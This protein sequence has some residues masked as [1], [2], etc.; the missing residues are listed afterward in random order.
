MKLDSSEARLLK[1]VLHR[2]GLTRHDLAAAMQ[3]SVPT[4]ASLVR[5]LSTSGAVVQS[6][7]A[8]STGGRPASRISISP[9]FGHCY[10]HQIL[11]GRLAS[12]A[13]DAQGKVLAQVDRPVKD[14]PTTFRAVDAAEMELSVKVPDRPALASTL[15]VPG[16]VDRTSN[17]GIAPWVYGLQHFEPA[18]AGCASRLV[19]SAG[20]LYAM[21]VFGQGVP[22]TGRWVAID[23]A[24]GLS[25]VFVSDK[26]EV[27]PLELTALDPTRSIV[28]KEEVEAAI[29]EAAKSPGSAIEK[30]LAQL[31]PIEA[32]C[33]AERAGDE[34][35]C[36]L[37]DST[38]S[39]TAEFVRSACR[40]MRPRRILLC[41]WLLDG[42]RCHESVRAA[43]SRKAG[44][45]AG[46]LVL[47]SPKDAV[48][49]RWI[50]AGLAGLDMRLAEMESGCKQV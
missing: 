23:M 3:T 27:V 39:R 29:L 50:G 7:A 20:A 49:Q 31:S 9:G 41:F 18:G 4:I 11:E 22:F 42:M 19:S 10:A 37:F 13:I 28:C 16:I 46:S 38:V 26:Q 21:Q 34:K 15:V 44:V 35:A 36:E 48:E 12:C 2:P 45:P 8:T 43:I 1:L 32:L 40:V 17:T 25:G 5:S 30:K 24:C 6:G 47:V 14:I 33:E